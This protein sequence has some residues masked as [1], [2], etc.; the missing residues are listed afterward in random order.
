MNMTANGVIGRL[1]LST[2]FI[3]TLELSTLPATYAIES[4]VRPN[5]SRSTGM[6]S[7]CSRVASVTW[8]LTLLR[9]LMSIVKI[10]TLIGYQPSTPILSV[11][12]KWRVKLSAV[13]VQRPL[14]LNTPCHSTSALST[15]HARNV[16][17]ISLIPRHS[18]VI[19]EISIVFHT[20]CV[21]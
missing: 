11:T 12:R 7:I 16:R 14:R 9:L 21:V 2:L 20:I 10:F 1:A 19:R 4:L 8:F 17:G 13:G 15:M 5:L 6:R 18:S 3:S